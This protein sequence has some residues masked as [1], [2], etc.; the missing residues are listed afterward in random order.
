[1]YDF[2]F[3]DHQLLHVGTQCIILNKV[4]RL[5]KIIKVFTV[6]GFVR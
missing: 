2:N 4:L 5:K 3:V 1:M 6:T